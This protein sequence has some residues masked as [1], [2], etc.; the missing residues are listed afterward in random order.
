VGKTTILRDVAATLSLWPSSPRVV[1]IDTS[2]EIGGDSSIPLAFLGRARRLQVPS[3]DRQLEV[4][5][6][7][8]QNHTPD[9]MIIDEIATGDE[10]DAAWAMTQR[11]VKLVATCHAE[12]LVRLVQNQ[13][14]NKLVGGASQAFLSNEERRIKQKLRKTVLERP[15]AS[16][17]DFLL[18]LHSRKAGTLFNDVNKAVDIVLDEEGDPSTRLAQVSSWVDL[19]KPLPEKLYPKPKLQQHKS[20]TISQPRQMTDQN[21]FLMDRDG[22]LPPDDGPQNT[23]HQQRFAENSRHIRRHSRHQS[24]NHSYQQQQ[25]YSPQQARR[26]DDPT[27]EERAKRTQELLKEIDCL[28]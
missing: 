21:G 18:E 6:Q 4:M 14:L 7:A 5:N 20:G 1:V 9:V 23:R 17:F 11:G 27:R 26:G 19:G 25:D 15:Y 13:Q 3:R 2:N 24:N 10:A 12:S 22:D 16:P 28:M 8:L